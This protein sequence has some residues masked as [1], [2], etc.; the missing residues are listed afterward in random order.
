M[1]KVV[2]S[3]YDLQDGNY[4]YKKGDKYPRSGLVATENRIS[5]LAGNMNKMGIALIVAEKPKEKQTEK[6]Q[7]KTKDE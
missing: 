2:K 4:L 3:F 6:K 7:K 1:F 5:E